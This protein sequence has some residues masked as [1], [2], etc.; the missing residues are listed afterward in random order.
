MF[1][2]HK[3][4]TRSTSDQYVLLRVPLLTS[5]STVGETHWLKQ[6][7]SSAVAWAQVRMYYNCL[8]I[9]ILLQVKC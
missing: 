4:Y 2:P 1:K 3:L 7:C 9:K 6:S 5:Y 8:S